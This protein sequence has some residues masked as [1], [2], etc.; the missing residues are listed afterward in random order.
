MEFLEPSS[1]KFLYEKCLEIF[2]N[3]DIDHHC[4]IFGVLW[5]TN[6]VNGRKL[7][8]A[9]QGSVLSAGRGFLKSLKI[10][11]GYESAT[12]IVAEAVSIITLIQH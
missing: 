5:A 8:V 7:F 11:V 9:I 4:I 10:S 3:L 12:D 6:R 1:C 2:V